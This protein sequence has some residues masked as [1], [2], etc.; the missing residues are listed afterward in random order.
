MAKK[1]E[2]FKNEYPYALINDRKCD[3]KE[4]GLHF[5]KNVQKV[6]GSSWTL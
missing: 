4:G 1:S 6:R 5:F 3:I 2:K